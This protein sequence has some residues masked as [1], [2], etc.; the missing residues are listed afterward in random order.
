M[1]KLIDYEGKLAID[2]GWQKNWNEP[3]YDRVIK[4]CPG[5]LA[6]GFPHLLGLEVDFTGNYARARAPYSDRHS[7]LGDTSD[8]KVVTETKPI[9]RPRDRQYMTHEWK[10]GRW[11][12]V[13]KAKGEGK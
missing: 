8:W 1:A 11:N 4:I 13:P 9:K 3:V 2:F 5:V 6:A 7:L 12:L 10:Y